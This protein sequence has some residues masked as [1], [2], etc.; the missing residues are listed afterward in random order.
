MKLDELKLEV[1][2]FEFDEKLYQK[3]NAT[4]LKNPKLVSFNKKACDLIDD[5]GGSVREEVS[6]RKIL[7]YGEVEETAEE[8]EP[9]K[10][11]KFKRGK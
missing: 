10:K 9:K 1:D 2:Y 6:S 8:E 11:L 4:P 3:L 7:R 5:Y